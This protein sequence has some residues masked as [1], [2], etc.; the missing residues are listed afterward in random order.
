M[1]EKLS[2]RKEE[3][4]KNVGETQAISIMLNPK[5]LFLEIQVVLG[6]SYAQLSLYFCMF[7]NKPTEAAYL[8]FHTQQFRKKTEGD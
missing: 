1:K 5:Y 2:D 3:S 4:Q 7:L 6:T 8:A